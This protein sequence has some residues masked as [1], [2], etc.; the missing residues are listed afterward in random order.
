MVNVSIL[1][2]AVALVAV[3]I[4]VIILGKRVAALEKEFACRLSVSTL[5]VPNEIEL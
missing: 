3:A 1:L 5:N 2:L 4:S